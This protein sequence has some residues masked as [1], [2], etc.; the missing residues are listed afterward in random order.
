MSQDS[1]FALSDATPIYVKLILLF[2]RRIESGQWPVGE[3]IPGL[4]TLASDFNVSRA[5]IRQAIAYLEREGLIAGSRGKGTYVIAKPHGQVWLE[6]PDTWPGLL[7]EAESIEAQWVDIERP[8]WE[9]DLSDISDAP[10]VAHYHVI[11]RVLSQN[12]VPYLIG[13]S[14]IDQRI[15]E[16]IGLDAFQRQA[17]YRLLDPWIDRIDQSLTV[18]TADAETAYLIQIPL[19]APVVIVRR[20]G[21]SAKGELV[22]QG[23]GILRGDFVR[24]E[25][26]LT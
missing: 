7:K 18:S 1:A 12:K 22:Y 17:L 5:T 6:I 26:V 19:N 9:P 15:V 20:A 23:E 8:L 16:E 14:Y 10:P 3:K 24:L 4:N 13:T 2:R 25:R 21:V 11:R